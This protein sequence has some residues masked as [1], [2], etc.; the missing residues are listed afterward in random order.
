[1]GMEFSR[2]ELLLLMRNLYEAKVVIKQKIDNGEFYDDEL[3]LA[4]ELKE[5]DHLRNK[6]EKKYFDM[7]S[8]TG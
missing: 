4:E 3:D 1:M 7:M 6:I 5:L 2:E 8:E